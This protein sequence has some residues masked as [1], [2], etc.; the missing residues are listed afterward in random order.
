MEACVATGMNVLLSY[1][2]QNTEVNSSEKDVR[3][4]AKA[5]IRASRPSCLLLRVWSSSAQRCRTAA[6]QTVWMDL[7]AETQALLCASLLKVVE[8]EHLKRTGRI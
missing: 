8:Q 3:L 7:P 2:P 6:H 5:L 1:I 4:T